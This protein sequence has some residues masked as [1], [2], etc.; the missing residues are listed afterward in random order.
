MKGK[1][2]SVFLAAMLDYTVSLSKVTVNQPVINQ[3]IGLK[4]TGSGIP[5]M[6]F[7]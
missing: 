4:I 2:E 1:F 7:I 5:G 6:L 3:V